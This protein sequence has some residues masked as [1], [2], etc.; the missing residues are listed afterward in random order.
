M[1]IDMI[2][3]HPAYWRHGHG[4]HLTNW[5]FDLS[6]EDSVGLGVAGVPMG[7]LLFQHLGFEE[8]ETVTIPGYEEHPDPIEAWLGIRDAKKE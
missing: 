8:V 2:V 3:T 1:V 5:F 6:A 7:K 4:S